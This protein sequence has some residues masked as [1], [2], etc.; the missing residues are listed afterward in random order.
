MIVL[1]D[2]IKYDVTLSYVQP[3]HV[4]LACASLRKPADL[5]VDFVTG[6][7]K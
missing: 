7:G 4:Y 1:A 2:K 6:T 5:E 3:N